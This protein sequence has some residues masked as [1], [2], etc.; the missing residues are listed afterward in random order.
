VCYRTNSC[1]YVLCFSRPFIGATYSRGDVSVSIR[2]CYDGISPG[3]ARVA[4]FVASPGEVTF[5]LQIHNA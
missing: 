2:A 4:A 5:R 1:E 3:D